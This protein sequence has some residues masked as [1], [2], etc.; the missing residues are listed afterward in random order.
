VPLGNRNRLKTG[1][2]S[3]ECKAMRRTIAQW[4]GETKA[5]TAR[6]EAEL[7]LLEKGFPSTPRSGGEG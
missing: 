3:N 6:A 4:R 1:R 5:L 7:E 2:H